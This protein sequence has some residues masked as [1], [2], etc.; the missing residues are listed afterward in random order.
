MKKNIKTFRKQKNIYVFEIYKRAY[1]LKVKQ[2][3]THGCHEG[4]F[5]SGDRVPLILKLGTR[6]SE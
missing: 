2:S 4:V 3:C 6:G 1:T 5:G